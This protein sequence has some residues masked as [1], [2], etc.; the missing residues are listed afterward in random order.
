MSWILYHQ[1]SSLP[2]TVQADFIIDGQ[3]I[4]SGKNHVK[5]FIYFQSV[6]VFII[7]FYQNKS[8]NT[9][10]SLRTIINDNVNIICYDSKDVVLQCLRSISKNVYNSLSPIHI[11][12]K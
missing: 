5:G 12:M 1:V 2:Y 8:I 4:S 3:V 9:I 10:F 11:P 7:M 6:L